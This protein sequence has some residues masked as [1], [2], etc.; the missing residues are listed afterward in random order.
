MS[1]KRTSSQ[2]D[3]ETR[4]AILVEGR[5]A[6]QQ[7]E[8]HL[9]EPM[10]A[11]GR[12]AWVCPAILGYRAFTERLW[13]ASRNDRSPALLTAEQSEALWR[14]VI[15]DS[16]EGGRL[17]GTQ[18]LAAW[19][20]DARQRLADW[21]VG[22]DGNRQFG[23]G[24][25][26]PLAKRGDRLFTEG[27]GRARYEGSDRPTHVGGGE[28]DF[29]IFLRW[30]SLYAARLA[31]SHWLDSADLDAALRTSVPAARGE[32]EMAEPFES[33]PSRQAL[34]AHLSAAGWR[35]GPRAIP[36]RPVLA[37]RT[38]FG[39][40]NAELTAAARWVQRRFERAP[41]RRFAVV[42]PR[43]ESRAAEV[44]RVFADAGAGD[45]PI[46]IAG[47]GPSL[48]A[49]P[50]VGAALNALELLSPRGGFTEF[51]R[52]LRSP[53]FAEEGTLERA[54]AA[55]LEAQWRG[56]LVAQ[57][58]F[59]TAYGAAGLRN[60]LGRELPRRAKRLDEALAELG[61]SSDSLA[62]S[63]WARRWQGAL[64]R[65]GFTDMEA[66]ERADEANV[67]ERSLSGLAALTPILGRISMPRAL[68]ELE[69]ILQRGSGRAP[70]PVAGIHVF[71][72]LADVGPGYEAAWV[73][74]L[75]ATA[76]PRGV[77]LNPLLPRSLQVGHGMP[78]ASPQD[79]LA[80]SRNLLISLNGFVGEA[81][82]SWPARENDNIAE[83][84]PLIA[85]VPEL[86][87]GVLEEVGRMRPAVRPRR[88]ETVVDP[89]VPAP[90]GPLAGGTRA[91]N[92]TARCP[93]RAF[94][95]FR[96]GAR[97]L[98]PLARGIP[99]RLKGIALHAA[100]ESFYR[101]YVSRAAL[102]G[103]SERAL[104]E[105]LGASIAA[106]LEG[107]FDA[108]AGSLQNLFELERM[109]LE[110]ILT[111][112]LRC[113]NARGAF[114]IEALEHRQTIAVGAWTISTRI[115][116]IDRLEDG[117]SAIIDYKSGHG[118]RPGDW[119]EP[120]LRDSQL[121]LYA[122][123]SDGRLSALIV[124]TLSARRVGY[125]G[126]WE[127]PEDFPGRSL[128]LPE[129]RRLAEQTVAWREGIALLAGE[130][131]AGDT[132]IYIADLDAARGAFAPLTRVQE[133]LALH[134][135]WIEPW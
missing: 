127:R 119:L 129:G 61:S 123:G 86:D 76:F 6:A 5:F 94:C 9:A 114:E 26:W 38:A 74:G 45:A 51:G 56:E 21:N 104:R 40:E 118:P 101:R 11:A 30:Q 85:E 83:P 33:T 117:S 17:L 4:A 108:A 69:R 41:T 58:P 100:L 128:P 24:R 10:L 1:I 29:A 32:V 37:S 7:W 116:R 135:G 60:G 50:L 23:D 73:T 133:Q 28:P 25:D 42:I 96:L 63:H 19:A 20:R 16:P 92:A 95:E 109:R 82:F 102:A 44:R 47:A 18:G 88:R 81:V 14:E 98:P 36:R 72:N 46:F 62:P 106:A 59:M 130:Y 67:W 107:V 22:E 124:A 12:A 48:D 70:M 53:F 64:N 93:L 134:R 13:A 80:R 75:T 89:L 71:E 131:A 57:L 68:D 115:D 91:L 54:A 103:A 126:I 79:A 66:E 27:V 77:A 8:L 49:R 15:A 87:P 31:D 113:E 99:A 120:R 110:R 121:P 55:R 43:L 34:F 52:W 2:V 97:P 78:W 90:G 3:A 65:L 111:E 125:S 122:T 105:E 35:I 112:F 39:D 132:S 84:S